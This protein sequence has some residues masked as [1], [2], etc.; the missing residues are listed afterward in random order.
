MD[1]DDDIFCSICYTNGDGTTN[2]Y[3][4]CSVF[5]TTDS[6]VTNAGNSAKLNAHYDPNEVPYKKAKVLNPIPDATNPIPSN[7]TPS[8]DVTL[9]KEAQTSN[10]IIL[11]PTPRPDVNLKKDAQ[12]SNPILSNPSPGPDVT[13]KKEAQTS[14]PPPHHTNI[15]DTENDDVHS[16]SFLYTNADGLFNKLGELKLNIDEKNPDIIAITEVMPKNKDTPTTNELSIPGYDIFINKNP[17]RGVLIYAKSQLNAVECQDLNNNNFEENTWISFTNKD[18]KSTLVGCLYKSPSTTK[19]N[20]EELWNLMR[21][22]KITKFDKVCLV[23][24]F[25]YPNINW[26]G[27]NEGQKE[28]KFIDSINDAFLVQMVTKPTRHREGQ[29]SNLL[30]LVL[31]NDD[32]MISDI[33]H[34]A[35]LGKSDHDVLLF[36]LYI[37]K[38]KQP[39][40]EMKSEYMYK[41]GNY[42]QMNE[43]A[44]DYDW[45]YLI[46]LS[47]EDQLAAIKNKLFQL[48]D[49]YVPNKKKNVR[50][51]A[52]PRWFT[53]RVIKKIKK[54]YKAY[55]LYDETNLW[56]DYL[57]YIEARDI[58]EGARKQAQ[59]DF[60][61]NI[62]INCKKEPKRFWKYVREKTKGKSGISPLKRENGDMAV[63]DEDKAETLNNFFGSVFTKEDESNLPESKPTEWS[64]GKAIADIIVTP[65]AI[66]EKL[67]KLNINKAYGPDGIPPIVLKELRESLST[68]LSYLFNKSIE[69]G[70]LPE[71]WKTANVTAIFK[72]GTKSEP[73]NYRPVSLTSVICK[74]F[75]SIVR[76]CIVDHMTINK[77]FSECQHGFRQHRSCVTQLLHV[78]EDLTKLLDDKNNID[79]IYFDFKKVFDTVPHKRLL[80]KLEYYGITGNILLWIKDFLSNRKQAVKVGSNFSNMIDVTSG[81]P[82]GSTLGPILFTI[83]IND[84]PDQV[85]S[86]CKIFADDTKIYN[87]TSES[88][89]LQDDI[90]SMI[91]WSEHWQLYFN[92]GKCKRMHI[93]KTN[94]K[95]EYTMTIENKETIIQECTEEK[96]LGVI[97]DNELKFDKHI[98]EAVKKASRVLGMIKRNFMYIDK[99]NLLLLYKGLVRPI[100]EYGNVIWA[101][102]LKRQSSEIEKIQRR[103]T[104]LIKEIKDEPYE[105]RLKLL[106][107][108]SL[109]ARRTREDLIQCYKIFRQ[110]DDISTDTF[111][112]QAKSQSTRNNTDKIFIRYSKLNIR[113]YCFTNRVAPLWNSLPYYIKNAPSTNHFKSF[114]DNWETFKNI[115]YSYDA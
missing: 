85:E 110:V 15:L 73:G 79:I 67:S 109:K 89:Q 63:S 22:E 56:K 87:I 24:D 28:C 81:I 18:K 94:S 83:F 26:E 14:N 37:P 40:E 52:K 76:D 1:N 113:K 9:K 11:N 5:D 33:T 17:K 100:L 53:N 107:L 82:Q 90:N 71:E 103:A 4:S 108:P 46:D 58:S 98:Q 13:L 42:K 54:K 35:K 70:A 93:G 78:M 59:R 47:V 65:A 38:E 25:N 64:G 84:L 43:E 88:K 27:T 69:S 102:Y 50:S 80:T 106:K 31:V 68:P 49:K 60:E 21:N 20:E 16:C 32:Q 30:D 29:Q 8:P 101:P 55:K 112:T 34:Y 51:K 114:I 44:Q 3:V 92:T 86:Y 6:R 77:L 48:I 74:V 23:G 105:R 97:I 39:T 7:P 104:K 75:E 10:H 66:E 12:T 99:E 111:F 62:A 19:E 57:D 115:M 95:Q 41:K 96:D 36:D 61:K 91:M 45:S 72:K 2:N